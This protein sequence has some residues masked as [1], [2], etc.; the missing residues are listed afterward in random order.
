[1]AKE[2]DSIAQPV[3]S[4]VLD[5]VEH[6]ESP[7][8]M[9]EATRDAA[10]TV[11]VSMLT[12]SNEFLSRELSSLETERDG[13][14]QQL[15]Q[16]QHSYGW[17]VI[18]RYRRWLARMRD[19]YTFFSRCYEA[20]ATWLLDRVVQPADQD[21]RTRYQ[22]WI[23][24]HQLGSERIEEI[25]AATAA[26]P[27]KPLVSVLIPVD[28]EAVAAWLTRSI[29]SVQAQLYDRWVLCIEACDIEA[30]IMALLD[31]H[32]ASDPRVRVKRAPKDREAA[33][34]LGSQ[35][36]FVTGEFV[37][38]LDQHSELSNDSLFEIVKR[39]NQNWLTD[40]IYWDEDKLEVDGSR[41][42]PFFKPDW[43][44]DLLLSMNYLG[45]SL[46][47]RTTLI[48][49]VAGVSPKFEA[50]RLYDLVLRT[51]ERTNRIAHVPK[52]LSHR[53]KGAGPT[54]TG[55]E[56]TFHDR[57]DGKR[58]IEEALQR[59]VLRGRA[60]ACSPGRYLVR[61]EIGGEPLVSIL[62]PT[63]DR[64]D[65]L[66][67]CLTSIERNTDY[68]N[69][70][71]IVLD[72]DS[73]APET[74]E[75][76]ERVADRARVYRCPGRFNFS[77]INNCGAKEARGEFLLFLNNDTE[78]IRRD[79]LNAMI[80]HAQRP[81]VGA[82]GAKLLFTDGRI[83]HAGIVLG[84]GGLTGHAF[85]GDSVPDRLRLTE[86][87]RDCSAV[88]AACL[89]MRRTLFNEV[90]GFDENLSVDLNDVDLCLRLRERGYLIVFQPLALLRHHESAT[91]G[92]LHR[93]HDQE[94]FLKRWAAYLKKG[95]PYYNR[96]LTLARE[97]WSV[98][99]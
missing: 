45:P 15:N 86:V 69:Y 31:H 93:A 78:V 98:A 17:K 97:D 52:V 70:E 32:T 23:A 74:L 24:R 96:N 19:R 66:R 59:R 43:N 9:A 27:Y 84:I 87:I 85:R 53:R 55:S 57:Y 33:E 2:D 51:V 44:P 5:Q 80:E 37:I 42:E 39:L 88:T 35:A 46:A 73:S 16:I 25:R 49:E 20:V 3:E 83:Q 28:S 8:R 68:P 92:R 54:A 76:L 4:K 62:I 58:A 12:A 61:Y 90:Q 10:L 13:L 99:D 38:F 48:E 21:E 36:G 29:E 95:D 67:Q 47:I 41:V 77:A 79:W 81:E 34:L 64:C 26:F 22:L 11:Q 7:N 18:E 94:L 56:I 72:N 40:L 89:M 71:I 75:F 50:S 63:K 14:R 30:G 60:T 82:V 6:L 65:L 1:M 91:R